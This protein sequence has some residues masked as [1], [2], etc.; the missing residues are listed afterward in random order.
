[1]TPKDPRTRGAELL[2]YVNHGLDDERGYDE[3]NARED[4]NTGNVHGKE[5]RFPRRAKGRGSY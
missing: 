5:R 2:V 4:L 1:M 3:L